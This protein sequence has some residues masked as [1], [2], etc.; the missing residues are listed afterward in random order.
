MALRIKLNQTEVYGMPISII[1][2]GRFIKDVGRMAKVH[3]NPCYPTDNTI[4]LSDVV[5]QGPF[6]STRQNKVPLKPGDK[7]IETL[8][9]DHLNTERL[10]KNQFDSMV[11]SILDLFTDLEV[12][13]DI[14]DEHT[15]AAWR[16]GL[17]NNK[18]NIKVP[19][20]F[21]VEK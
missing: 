12:S 6:T 14:V 13:C 18:Q 15:G 20:N 10:T 9:R 5:P 16:I 3:V 8:G 7:R 17:V 21:P 4:M 11:S 19:K 2:L 1:N